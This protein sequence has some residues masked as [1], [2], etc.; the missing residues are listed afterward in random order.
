VLILGFLF[1]FLILFILFQLWVV[2]FGKKKYGFKKAQ[3]RA[4]ILAFL[5][6]IFLVTIME[7]I[8]PAI[9]WNPLIKNESIIVGNWVGLNEVLELK[10]DH[11]FTLSINNQMYTGGWSLEDWNLTFDYH[12]P[13]TPYYYLRVIHHSDSYHLVKD[14]LDKDPEMWSHKNALVKQ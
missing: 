8:T 4:A 11:T 2:G 5:L 12:S 10:A 14:T 6:P 13:N 1:F 7:L 9:E 3:F